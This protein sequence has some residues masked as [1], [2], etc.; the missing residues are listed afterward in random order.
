VLA[1]E[2]GPHGVRVVGLTPGPISDTEGFHRL[3]DVK[4][5]GNKDASKKASENKA[6]KGTEPFYV[7]VQRWGR[8]AD[9][10]NAALFLGSPAS[11]YVTGHNLVID[12][13]AYLTLPNMM[14]RRPEFVEKW[15]QAKL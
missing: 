12:G 14:F 1:C 8:C 7:P 2:W 13:G 6:R 11:S 10:S 3:G 9:I 15:Q 4:N 5:I